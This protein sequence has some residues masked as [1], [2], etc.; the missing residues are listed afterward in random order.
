[1]LNYF[2]MYSLV[3]GAI[4]VL[5]QLG[6]SSLNA[7]LSPILIAFFSITI[8]VSVILGY[9]FRNVFN[10]ARG[11]SG[12]P[13][14]PLAYPF[15]IAVCTIIGLLQLGYVPIANLI[16]GNFDY[17]GLLAADGSVLRTASVVGS[18]FGSVYQFA[19]YFERRDKGD[20]VCIF[21]YLLI[22]SLYAARSNWMICLFCFLVVFTTHY[23]N[24]WKH[25]Y[26]FIVVLIALAALW[27][28]GA[29]GNIRSGG[30]WDDS[31]FIYIYGRLNGRWPDFIPR[32]FGW[33]YIY[34]TSP[35]ANL[36]YNLVS[37][38]QGFTFDI[39]NFIYDFLPMFIAKV[40]P[41]YSPLQAQLVVPY[42][43][44]SSVWTN[45]LVHF[46]VLGLMLGYIGQM[47]LMWLAGYISRNTPFQSLCFV[48]CT[49]CVAFS[50]FVNSFTYPSMSYPLLISVMFSILYVYA[51]SRHV[52]FW[53]HR[54]L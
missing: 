14:L 11:L 19:I 30:F 23:S 10:K 31:S 35:L 43:T 51:N 37:T 15:I 42:L 49:E 3:W 47:L 2:Y 29:Y 4:L 20:L 45:Y 17:A 53:S 9:R 8:I 16:M 41:N 28:F 52:S 13:K 39:C 1:M 22:I 33:A 24:S 12:L 27:L 21:F 26:L 25:K 7:P 18:I 36:N 40:L 44:V 5:Y 50:F 6:W 48:F 34:L 38:T 54:K 32:Q 46:G